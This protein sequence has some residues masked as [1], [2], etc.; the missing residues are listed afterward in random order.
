MIVYHL[1][2]PCSQYV[3]YKATGNNPNQMTWT[4]T[5]HYSTYDWASNSWTIL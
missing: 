4:Y 3:C 2:G 1:V 5:E